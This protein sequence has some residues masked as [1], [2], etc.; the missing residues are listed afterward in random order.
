VLL[1]LLLAALAGGAQ[2]VPPGSDATVQ[3]AQ[4]TRVRK[5]PV[6]A[7]VTGVVNVN[8]ASEAELRLLP[9]IGR[10]RARAIIGRRAK[11]PFTSVEEVGRMKGMKG[12]VRKLRSHLTVQGDTTL[13]PVPP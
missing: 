2:A 7:A 12:I 5:A 10:G 3:P 4:R 9:G 11:R 1:L 8:R 6:K 13:R